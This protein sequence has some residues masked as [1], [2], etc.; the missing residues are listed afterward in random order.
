MSDGLSQDQLDICNNYK[1]YFLNMVEYINKREKGEPCAKPIKPKQSLA[2]LEDKE[3]GKTELTCLELH[4]ELLK[5]FS[6]D[7]EP[8]V[9]LDF[10]EIAKCLTVK[11][12]TKYLACCVGMINQHKMKG[13]AMFIEFGEYLTMTKTLYDR[14]KPAYSWKDFLK[15]TI[16]YDPGNASKCMSVFRYFGRF[17]KFRKLSIPLNDLHKKRDLIQKYMMEDMEFREFWQN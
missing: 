9:T 5:Y 16:K 14:E 8:D 15:N 13:M 1:L 2:F 12:M 6:K 10:S 7:S 11:E 3:A 17:P 4:T